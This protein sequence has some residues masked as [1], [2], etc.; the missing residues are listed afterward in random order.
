MINTISNLLKIFFDYNHVYLFF[1]IL[2]FSV[3]IRN[4]S[5][6]H[7]RYLLRDTDCKAK[8]IAPIIGLILIELFE[9]ATLLGLL[10]FEKLL[11]SLP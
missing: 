10:L 7:L 9:S 1:N 4:S 5:I 6:I 2:Y 3:I 11:P 8:E